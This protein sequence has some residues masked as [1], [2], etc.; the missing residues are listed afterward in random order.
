MADFPKTLEIRNTPGGMIWQIYHVQS[1]NEIFILTR[2]S[3]GNGFHSQTV[4]PF[5]GELET[6]PHWRNDVTWTD[7]TCPRCEQ[8]PCICVK[9]EY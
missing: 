3:Q 7:K 9:E 6:F 1:Q 5:N 2:N 8:K 4:V